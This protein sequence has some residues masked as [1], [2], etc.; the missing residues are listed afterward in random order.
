MK[1]DDSSVI[2]GSMSSTVGVASKL[3]MLIDDNA[4]ISSQS[5]LT[6]STIN[7]GSRVNKIVPVWVSEWVSD[8]EGVYNC[9][10]S[11][12]LLFFFY[13]HRLQTTFYFDT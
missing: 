12:L 5:M 8:W 6:Q 4:S 10:Q 11:V 3:S 2:A 1:G 7:G 9:V 13:L